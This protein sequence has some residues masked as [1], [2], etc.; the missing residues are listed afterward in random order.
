MQRKNETPGDAGTAH[1]IGATTAGQIGP[2]LAGYTVFMLLLVHVVSHVDR[3]ILGILLEPIKQDLGYSDTQLGFLSG[4]A[5]ALFYATLGIP[6]AWLA[7]RRNRRNFVAIACALWSVMT[8]ACGAAQNF[9]QLALARIGVAVGESGAG[10]ASVSMISSLYP[11]ERRARALAVYA[12]ASSIGVLIGHP[13]GGTISDTWGWRYAFV[14]VAAPGILLALIVRFTVPE[15]PRDVAAMRSGESMRTALSHIWGSSACRYLMLGAAISAFLAYGLG[16]WVPA[17]LMRSHDMTASGVGLN[18]SP[19]AGLCGMMGG[20]LGGQLADRLG[21]R[22]AAWAAR[23]IT[24]AKLVAFP[25]LVGFFLIPKLSVALPVYFLAVFFGAVYL[26][27]TYAMIQSVVPAS[28]RATA[29]AV[30]LLVINLIGLGL[31]PQLVGILSDLFRETYGV[32][33]L[34]MALAIFACAHVPGALLYWIGGRHYRRELR[35]GSGSG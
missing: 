33:S 16:S 1:G 2:R 35:E 3:S 5:F 20:L 21:A 14:A 27:P 7:D 24:I 15:P 23:M 17:Y 13:I 32:E 19:I 28:M 12:L 25:L 29:A 10:P 8:A 11:R 6:A 26:G 4:I 22:D 30:Q 18:V 31:G 34:R 9:L